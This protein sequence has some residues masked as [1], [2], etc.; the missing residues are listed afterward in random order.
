LL[1]KSTFRK[2]FSRQPASSFLVGLEENPGVVDG[3]ELVEESKSSWRQAGLERF[4]FG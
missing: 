1:P 4:A 2:V 3:I